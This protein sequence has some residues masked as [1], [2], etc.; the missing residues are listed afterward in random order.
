MAKPK[1][2]KKNGIPSCKLPR[3]IKAIDCSVQPVMVINENSGCGKQCSKNKN[4][5]IEHNKIIPQMAN[6]LLHKRP[7][8]CEENYLFMMKI[9][10]CH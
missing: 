1:C 7:A 2:N 3:L 8:S 5:F 10:F 6:D 4:G 9:F